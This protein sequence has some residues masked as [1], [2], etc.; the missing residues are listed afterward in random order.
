[1]SAE[2][3]ELTKMKVSEL[4]TMAEHLGIE[5]PSKKLKA[6]L[7]KEIMAKQKAKAP[8]LPEAKAKA[9][10]KA[11][12]KA[13]VEKVTAIFVNYRQGMFRQS[14]SNVLVRIPEMSTA[15][16]ASKYI[17]R[18][19]IWQSQTGKKLIGKI[20][21]THGQGGVLLAR[22]R[23]GLPGQALGSRLEVL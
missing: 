12:G 16:S 19:V 6:Q 8:P 5:T 22:F 20:I 11:K 15:S 4:K 18:K 1:L 7:I 13:P 10:E 3:P 17:G 23:K 14:T 21:S 2:K 9:P